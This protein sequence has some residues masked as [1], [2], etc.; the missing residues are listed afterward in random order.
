M[1]PRQVASETFERARVLV[2]PQNEAWGDVPYTKQ[3]GLWGV[4][5]DYIHITPG[6]VVN[7]STTSTL[8]SR[9][10]QFRTSTADFSNRSKTACRP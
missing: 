6:F 2:A 10:Q 3:P 8:N 5:G 7:S 1:M 4:E 9:G